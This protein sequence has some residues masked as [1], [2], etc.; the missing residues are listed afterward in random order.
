[1]RDVRGAC[2]V[3]VACL[4]AGGCSDSQTPYSLIA[5]LRLLGAKSEPAEVAPESRVALTAYAVDPRGG[6][7]TIDW[8]AC[9]DPSIPGTG[10]VNTDCITVDSAPYLL[11]LGE[12]ASIAATVPM[13][14][15]DLLG[16]P[17]ATGGV[18]LPVRLRV[19]EAD[20]RI[21]G[22]YR[23][24]IA[25]GGPPNHNPTL[26]SVDDVMAGAPLDAGAPTPE[27]A[28]AAI[29][30]RASFAPG[31]AEPYPA[32]QPDGTEK[33]VCETLSVS[34]FSTAGRF[35]SDSTGRAS[36]LPAC[37]GSD[38]QTDTVLQLD[39]AA[40]PGSVVDLYVVARDERGG[41]DFAHRRLVV[42]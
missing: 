31:S 20:A 16:G 6:E 23:M 42:E 36:D 33:P 3:L 21:D 8:A 28:G 19:F 12:G 35:S 17:D 5:G 41:L 27:R 18:Y 10:S 24:R 32:P 29:T 1:M 14:G 25:Q 30:L 2:A 15:A 40:A 26:A 22:I 9:V 39:T 38:D 37:E 11:P 4:F 7:F 13:L 34:W